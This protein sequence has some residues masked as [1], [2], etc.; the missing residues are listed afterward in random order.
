MTSR[1]NSMEHTP[2]PWELSE[3]ELGV[4]SSVGS[5]WP[6]ARMEIGWTPEERRANA[7]L[8]AAA[9]ELLEA[10]EAVVKAESNIQWPISP[11]ITTL[12]AAIAKA[13]GATHED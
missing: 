2:G 13:K 9:P 8:I 6:I 10:A 3:N 1:R 5:T 7:R 4:T 12:G 11:W